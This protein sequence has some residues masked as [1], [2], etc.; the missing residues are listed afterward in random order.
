MKQGLC[1]FASFVIRDSGSD[2][3]CEDRFR[4]LREGLT[5]RSISKLREKEEESSEQTP[6]DEFFLTSDETFSKFSELH[7]E[8]NH[9]LSTHESIFKAEFRDCA[10][11]LLRIAFIQIHERVLPW[12]EDLFL[13]DHLE[14]K[15]SSYVK[16]MQQL[17]SRFP[18]IIHSH[19]ITSFNDEVSQLWFHLEP[20]R[21]RIA[22]SSC[23]E[24]WKAKASTF[25][26]CYKLARALQTLPYSTA[27]IERTF[28]R[29][30]D[31]QTLKRNRIG[32]SNLEACLFVKQ[33][34]AMISA[35]CERAII[36]KYQEVFCPPPS[37]RY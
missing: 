14:L 20:L 11:K 4:I 27:S 10:V 7:P 37:Y 31:I 25:P 24:A 30:T 6:P 22:D 36:K 5:R 23:T 33:E 35:S 19:E 26:L 32:I 18:N 15:G 3:S 13:L 12:C 16:N 34:R 29:T 8:F 9:E 28:S 21:T 2:T 17:G 1:E